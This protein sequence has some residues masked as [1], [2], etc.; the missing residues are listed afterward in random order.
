[1]GLPEL[2]VELNVAKSRLTIAFCVT[3]APLTLS[4]SVGLV[5]PIP[6]SEGIYTVPPVFPIFCIQIRR[7]HKN[8]LRV[9]A[10][11]RA[12]YNDTLRNRV[13][14]GYRACPIIANV[15]SM[16]MVERMRQYRFCRLNIRV[17]R[18][19]FG[20]SQIRVYHRGETAFRTG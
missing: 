9:I 20:R 19:S 10:T 1:M 6:T 2:S 4:F 13:G 18:R 8:N 5:V 7:V 17:F 16:L 12:S 15:L 14:G 11:Q 3:K